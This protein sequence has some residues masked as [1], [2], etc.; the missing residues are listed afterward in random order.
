MLYKIPNS[1]TWSH[2]LSIPSHPILI[3]FNPIKTTQDS[4]QVYRMKHNPHT[5]LQT[6]YRMTLA[7][8]TYTSIL[9]A[10]CSGSALWTYFLNAASMRALSWNTSSKS[11]TKAYQN[12]NF[13]NEILILLKSLTWDFLILQTFLF[14]RYR[15][16]KVFVCN[17]DFTMKRLKKK[18]N[19]T[20][21]LQW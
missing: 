14:Y 20:K 18:G 19:W 2:Y 9:S 5:Y 7:W 8:Q 12:N 21:A 16:S 1:T 4:K 10:F 13:G 11:E 3:Q 15:S 6:K 17:T